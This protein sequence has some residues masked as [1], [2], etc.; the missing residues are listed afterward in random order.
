MRKFLI[1]LGAVEAGADGRFRTQLFPLG[2]PIQPVGYDY[3]LL[4]DRKDL[5]KLAGKLNAAK[6]EVPV[7]LTH[8]RFSAE[9]NP[10]PAVG[11]LAD[12]EVDSEGLWGFA[13]WLPTPVQIDGQAMTVAE[14]IRTECL[15]YLSPGFITW[16]DKQGREHP[17][18]L[19]EASLTNEPALQ[20]MAPVE[21]AVT[22]S[23]QNASERKETKRMDPNKLRALLG[24]AV[25]AS[26]E[27]TN[28]ALEARLASA[29][30]APPVAELISTAVASAVAEIRTAT[31]AQ[32]EAEYATRERRARVA[33]LMERAATEGKVVADNRE[34][35]ERQCNA[36][37]DDFEAALPDLPVKAPVKPWFKPGDTA[38][39]ETGDD[40]EALH[41]RVLSFQ[42]EQLKA[43][44]P[45][46]YEAAVKVVTAKKVA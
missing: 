32:I 42:V 30:E 25:D 44:T 39:K 7:N 33:A 26:D 35:L 41:E 23:P 17:S 20:G 28:A 24:L 40:R 5:E 6:H 43:G 45:V 18:D 36:N 2:G 19:F 31:A 13:R 3:Q 12:F 29:P 11:W 46:T 22:T 27:E 38:T 37:P 9:G 8:L 21:A 14:L 10:K 16:K 4:C 34:R 1:K 15:K